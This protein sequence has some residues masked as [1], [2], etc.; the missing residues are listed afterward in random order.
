MRSTTKNPASKRPGL[1]LAA[2]LFSSISFAQTQT[3]NAT[4]DASKTGAPISKYIYGQFLEHAGSLVNSG[5]WAEMLDDRKFYNPVTS[6]PPAEPEGPAWRRRM[7]PHHWMPVGADEFV[8][9][10][11]KRAYTGDHSPAV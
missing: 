6:M 4:I 7:A 11:A 10:D 9:M 1:L 8:T 3:V 2:L 5:I